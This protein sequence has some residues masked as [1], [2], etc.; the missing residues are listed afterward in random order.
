[1]IKLTHSEKVE[2]IKSRLGKTSSQINAE[3]F[4][5][6]NEF[7][8]KKKEL[9]KIEREQ[10]KAKEALQKA[11]RAQEEKQRRIV[12]KEAKKASEALRGARM[13][14]QITES[15]E[16]KEREKKAREWI[17][18]KQ[19]EHTL[20]ERKHPLYGTGQPMKGSVKDPEPINPTPHWF[21]SDWYIKSQFEEYWYGDN[22]ECR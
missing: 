7:I 19:W 12:Q 16:R 2:A 3:R 18:I 21:T 10:A 15:K 22:Y 4:A 6:H 1:M 17:A 20:W 8:N 14:I 9:D 11:Q 5:K 13:A